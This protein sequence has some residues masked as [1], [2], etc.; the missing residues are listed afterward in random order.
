MEQFSDVNLPDVQPNTHIIGLCGVNDYLYPQL[1]QNGKHACDP[2]IDGWMISDFY[3]L[4]H[5]FRGVGRSQAWF[6]CL[7]PVD[8]IRRYGE[9]A[10]GNSY[11][12]RRVVLDEHQVPD[13]STL[14]V[15]DADKLLPDFLSYLRSQCQVARNA[16]EPVLLCVFCH[17]DSL[18]YGLEIGGTE[19][20][21]PLLL[22][23]DVSKVLSDSEGVQICLLMT[24][25]FSGGWTITPELRDAE[26]KSRATIMTAAG[27]S[28]VS[29][30]WPQTASLGR[31]CGSIYISALI[32]VLESDNNREEE[33]SAAHMDTKEFAGAITSELLNVIDPRFGEQHKHQFEVQDDQWS[34]LYQQRTGIPL[35]R[36]RE[37]LQTLRVIPPRPITDI[38]LDRS[39]TEQ[40]VEAWEAA[41]PTAPH[42]IMAA[43]NYGGSMHAVKKAIHKKAL[44]YMKSHPGQDNLALNHAPHQLIN[45]CIHTPHLLQEVA[46]GSLWDILHYRMGSMQLAEALVHRLGL[47]APKACHW[48]QS[49]W[50]I[51]NGKTEACDR[52]EAY[53]R[54]ILE[55]G[56]LPPPY[57][58]RRHYDKAL[59]YLA[60]ACAE[61]GLPSSEIQACLN[62]A[63]K[64]KL[65]LIKLYLSIL[66]VL[67][68]LV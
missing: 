36:Y 24:S 29:E 11:G 67:T 41:H 32:N 13:S 63:Q 62:A 33:G 59:W 42:V 35:T 22:V 57:N 16:N 25:C 1:G 34:D 45:A 31:T 52:A 37:L 15:E 26:N 65:F 40:E 6:T 51:K 53:Y 68:N 12:P 55:A 3:L 47:K 4:H 9:F 60:V 39:S 21:G 64:R 18:T 14:R 44:E 49:D 54:I 50:R 7:D 8:L 43:S 56:L 30:S 27:H 2:T 38:R 48:D 17:G 5:L 28:V 23:D 19:E 20:G 58:S 46:W 66:V 61:S 10:H